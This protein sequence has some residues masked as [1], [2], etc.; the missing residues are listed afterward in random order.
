MG[1]GEHAEVVKDIL[2]CLR[3]PGR[4]MTKGRILAPKLLREAPN[5]TEAQAD[6]LMSVLKQVLQ[7]E[8]HKVRADHL[9]A[10]Q[11]AQ[12]SSYSAEQ[13]LVHDAR[14]T[15]L[16]LQSLSMA[17]A[18]Y[19]D[20]I[21][22]TDIARHCAL[23]LRTVDGRIK[24]AYDVLAATIAS[25]SFVRPGSM[26]TSDADNTSQKTRSSSVKNDQS[27]THISHIYG[28]YFDRSPV[29]VNQYQLGQAPPKN[30]PKTS[31]IN[32][33]L[34]G[35]FIMLGMAVIFNIVLLWPVAGISILIA[36]IA[37]RTS[38]NSWHMFNHW[39]PDAAEDDS[40]DQWW[41]VWYLVPWL[42]MLGLAVYVATFVPSTL[43]AS[44]YTWPRFAFCL[45]CLVL[46]GG[47]F[48]LGMGDTFWAICRQDIPHS[49]SK[50]V[51]PLEK[52]A[53][54]AWKRRWGAVK[55]YGLMIVL[56]SIALFAI[57]LGDII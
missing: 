50:F 39:N 9:G 24:V 51:E 44:A 8:L 45:R 36:F 48:L 3:V 21:T 57:Y 17:W 41:Y 15:S 42:W 13:R 2:E 33:Q 22:R 43:A 47:L 53:E 49:L 34:Q 19:I 7:Q 25:P 30:L 56:I 32:D 27:T 40:S 54:Y 35:V 26:N 16:H 10:E 14:A 37:W 11:L 1:T 31:D 23:S 12:Y 46:S 52:N 5:R 20:D 38:I 28:A 18:N 6:R 4:N 55:L 29:T